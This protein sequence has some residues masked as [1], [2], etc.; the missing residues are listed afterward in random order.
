[1]TPLA[2]VPHPQSHQRGEQSSEIQ[3]TTATSI[4]SARRKESH[5]C[6][7]LCQR[8]VGD[9]GITRHHNIYNKSTGRMLVRLD[10]IVFFNNNNNNSNAKQQ[11]QQKHGK[12]KPTNEKFVEQSQCKLYHK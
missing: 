3:Q 9:D 1:M 11:Q 7:R 10:Y 12:L 4:H 2:I 6:G 5:G 8:C